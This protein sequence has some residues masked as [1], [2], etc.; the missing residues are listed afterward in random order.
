MSLVAYIPALHKGYVDFFRKYR[1]ST[2]YILGKE[3][4]GEVPR[5][6]RDIRALEPEEIR[7]AIE[8]WKIFAN[9][10]VLTKKT[11]VELQKAEEKVVMPDEDVSRHFAETYLK[12]KNIAFVPIFLRWDKQISTKEFEVAP[13]RIISTD[14]FDREVMGIAEAEAKKSPD[15]WR[16][17]GGIII[18]DGKPVLTAHN[19]PLPSDTFGALGDP[20]SNFDAGEHIEL[21]KILHTEAA[22]IANAAK[23]GVALEGTSLYITT[24]P[25]PVCAKSVAHAGI[26]QVYYARGYSLLDAENILKSFG[27]KITLVK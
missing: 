12:Q 26:K 11:L 16:Q 15:W 24:F 9:V 27:V 20:R 3:L 14:E 21:S 4:V 17:I 13:D 1:G 2:L 5:M 18:K 22:L 23:R 8:S 6:D 25:C 7:Q 19:A 10:A